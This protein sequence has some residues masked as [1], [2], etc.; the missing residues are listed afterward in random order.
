[1]SEACHTCE[2]RPCKD[3]RGVDLISDTLPYIQLWYRGPNALRVAI[4]SGV[5]GEVGNVVES[6]GPGRW[7]FARVR[8]QNNA[9]L[10]AGARHIGLK[11][12]MCTA[13]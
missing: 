8:T 5:Y 1:M 2:V 12:N 7:R 3:R 9:R 4:V 10:I 11:S 13:R 6:H